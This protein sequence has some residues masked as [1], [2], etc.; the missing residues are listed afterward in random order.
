MWLCWKNK[1]KQH[2]V[3]SGL[4]ML[5]LAVLMGYDD[6]RISDDRRLDAVEADFEITIPENSG[7]DKMK[8]DTL[9]Q[10][11]IREFLLVF[12]RDLGYFIY[13]ADDA[14]KPEILD[15]K[16]VIQHNIFDH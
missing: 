3:V 16:M 4:L 11:I 10:G 5:R 2:Q 9:V 13:D 6:D 12:L 15:E 1:T 8:Q 14:K 7:C